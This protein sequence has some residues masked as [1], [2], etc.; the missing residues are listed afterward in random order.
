MVD[1]QEHNCV[2]VGEI[3]TLKTNQENMGVW[4]KELRDGLKDATDQLRK[5]YWALITL[6]AS[7]ITG[8]A[9]AGLTGLFKR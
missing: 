7:I 5:I 2:Q 6:A 8:V 4:I 9:V 1:K 3:A